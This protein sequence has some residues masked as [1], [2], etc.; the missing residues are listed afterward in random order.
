MSKDHPM[1]IESTNVDKFLIDNLNFE[2]KNESEAKP[3]SKKSQT[4]H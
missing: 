2:T 1:V 3:I 4:I